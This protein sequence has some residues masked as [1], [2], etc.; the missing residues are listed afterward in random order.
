MFT[1]WQRMVIQTKS[2]KY[3]PFSLSLFNF[4][5]GVIWVIYAVLIFDPYVLVTHNNLHLN[6]PSP[7]S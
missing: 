5:N 2:V 3:M 1:F 7:Y 6:V 4:L